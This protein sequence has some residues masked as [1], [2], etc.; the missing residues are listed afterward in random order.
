[1]VSQCNLVVPTLNKAYKKHSNTDSWPSIHTSSPPTKTNNDSVVTLFNFSGLRF[2]PASSNICLLSHSLGSFL[3]ILQVPVL[4]GHCK[5]PFP[6]YIHQSR[7]L[8]A[9]L[10]CAFLDPI[11]VLLWHVPHCFTKARLL[12]YICHQIDDALKPNAYLCYYSATFSL[13][14][15]IQ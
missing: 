12:L 5:R 7:L 8:D 6:K 1:M 4:K 13:N 14:K 3:P 11:Q 15:R 10:M 2:S 9:P